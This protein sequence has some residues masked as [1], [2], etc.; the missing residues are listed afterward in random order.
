MRKLVGIIL[1]SIGPLWVVVLFLHERLMTATSRLR[2]MC[3]ECSQ[4]YHGFVLRLLS[5]VNPNLSQAEQLNVLTKIAKDADCHMRNWT[6]QRK[7]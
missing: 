1:C 5:G 7:A 3:L 2:H 4:E 6:K